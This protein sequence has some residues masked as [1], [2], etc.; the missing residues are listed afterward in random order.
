MRLIN[1]LHHDYLT[2]EWKY[3]S[4]YCSTLNLALPGTETQYSG[5]GLFTILTELSGRTDV[6]DLV[7]H[8]EQS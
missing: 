3:N 5:H 1:L 4:T 7:S 8:P 2:R 6:L